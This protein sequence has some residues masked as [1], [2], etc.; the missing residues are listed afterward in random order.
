MITHSLVT[1]LNQSKIG[2]GFVLL[3]KIIGRKGYRGYA[4]S[5]VLYCKSNRK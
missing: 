5:Y 1:G 2:V 4:V 3:I